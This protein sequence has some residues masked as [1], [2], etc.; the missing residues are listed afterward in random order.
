MILTIVKRFTVRLFKNVTPESAADWV[1]ALFHVIWQSLLGS[2]V[3]A[4]ALSYMFSKNGTDWTTV[5]IAMGAVVVPAIIQ[6]LK[7]SPIQSTDK[8]EV[9]EMVVEEAVT[10]TIQSSKGYIAPSDI[11]DDPELIK[12]WKGNKDE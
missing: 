8:N 9:A 2:G 10:K 7:Q 6:Y 4:A 5:K 3:I 1:L 12:K 11:P